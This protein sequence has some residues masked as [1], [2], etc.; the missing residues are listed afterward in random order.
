MIGHPQIPEHRVALRLCATCGNP[1]SQGRGPEDLLQIL[2]LHKHVVA[3]RKRNLAMAPSQKHGFIVVA[4]VQYLLGYAHGQIN[5]SYVYT[6]LS[7]IFPPLS[8]LETNPSDPSPPVGKQKFSRCCLQA[9]RESYVIKDGKVL[10]NPDQE[11]PFISLSPSELNSTQ[12]PCGATF[13]NKD[14]GAPEVTVP[15]SWC[16]SNCGGWQRSTGTALSEWVQPFVG[17]ILP[18]AVFCLN[19][20][21]FSTQFR[22]H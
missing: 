7:E 19:V 13:A 16:N 8:A 6:S 15:Y 22:A 17:F 12:W 18:S 5:E 1:L 21:P 9:V 2:L 14:D 4:C 11:N 20:S 10:N 3:C